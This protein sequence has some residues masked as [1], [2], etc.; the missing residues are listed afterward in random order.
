MPQV[1]LPQVTVNNTAYQPAKSAMN[2]KIAKAQAAE[3]ALQ[4]MGLLKS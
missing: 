3:A 2:K 1:F 4:A